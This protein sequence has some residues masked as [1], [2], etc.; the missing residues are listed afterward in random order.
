MQNK[1]QR[2][3][4]IST[5]AVIGLLLIST[6]TY[7]LIVN[8]SDLDGQNQSRPNSNVDKSDVGAMMSKVHMEMP[9]DEVNNAI[10]DPYQCAQS[11]SFTEGDVR[12]DME[13][14]QYGDKAAENHLDITYMNDKVWGT[15]SVRSSN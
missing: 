4:L 15:T 11:K 12:Y 9:K 14:C 6:V 13:H 1:N 3:L 8:K 7:F 10:G 5:L 2:N